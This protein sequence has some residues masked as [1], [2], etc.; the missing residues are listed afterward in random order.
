MCYVTTVEKV[1]AVKT[2]VEGPVETMG[3]GVKAKWL[4]GATAT[5]TLTKANTS[6]TRGI[7]CRIQRK[8]M[9]PRNLL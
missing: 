4:K 9:V 5:L 3:F 2:A 6:L 1:T 7:C 8:H